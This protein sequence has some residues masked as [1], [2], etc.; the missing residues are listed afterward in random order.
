MKAQLSLL[1]LATML[2]ASPVLGATNSGTRAASSADLTGMPAVRE[3]TQVNYEKYETRTSTK[4]YDQQDAKIFIIHN[5]R[6]AVRCIN[7]MLEIQIGL[8][9]PRVL[10]HIVASC[11]ANII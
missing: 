8:F 6:I 11:G 3:R 4:T 10:K 2:A 1:V 9:A 5:L 7:S